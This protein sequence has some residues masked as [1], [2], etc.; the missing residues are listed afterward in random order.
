MT[1]TGSQRIMLMDQEASKTETNKDLLNKIMRLNL[2]DGVHF[3]SVSDYLIEDF[4]N[5]NDFNASALMPLLVARVEDTE[6]NYP[7]EVNYINIL[8]QFIKTELS[9]FKYSEKVMKSENNSESFIDWIKGLNIGSVSF[10]DKTIP[11]GP[12]R[13]SIEEAYNKFNNTSN[14][15]DAKAKEDAD[16]EYLNEQRETIYYMFLDKAKTNGIT[17]EEAKKYLSENTELANYLFNELIETS[18]DYEN[19]LANGTIEKKVVEKVNGLHVTKLE[20]S[21]NKENPNAVNDVPKIILDG[22]G[23]TSEPTSLLITPE[24]NALLEGLS[25]TYNDKKNID[26]IVNSNPA[27]V[28]DTAQKIVAGDGEEETVMDEPEE[29]IDAQVKLDQDPIMG[30]AKIR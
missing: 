5:N 7:N 13:I 8:N 9:D 23:P 20:D 15:Y 21:M 17:E 27:P 16:L 12:G 2:V 22:F 28:T 11:W 18:V 14:T 24:R 19:E 29:F 6:K 26:E 30:Q 1:S 10:T 3:K 4:N 25:V